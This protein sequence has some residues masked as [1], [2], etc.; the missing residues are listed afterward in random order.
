[1][2]SKAVLSP[3][4][5]LLCL[6]FASG[7]FGGLRG[8]EQASTLT[9]DEIVLEAHAEPIYPDAENVDIEYSVINHSKNAVIVAISDGLMR[10]KLIAPDGKPVRPY[11]YRRDLSS[12]MMYTT[13]SI[14]PGGRF[15]NGMRI[16]ALYPFPM[17]GVYRCTLTKRVYEWVS[18]D[19][20][21]ELYLYETNYYGK[22]VDVTA[23]E[24]RFQ[25]LKPTRPE[26][27][28]PKVDPMNHIEEAG[29][30]Y[31]KMPSKEYPAR[32][33]EARIEKPHPNDVRMLPQDNDL[34]PSAPQ[35][36]STSQNKHAT[37]MIGSHESSWLVW[38]LVVLAATVCA[39]WVFLRKTK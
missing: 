12:S 13:K 20:P 27:S 33:G 2:K 8:A 26:R 30:E 23:P 22:P 1:M 39:G 21:D 34:P 25:V 7:F 15:D 4:F 3:G 35:P 36:A 11:P 6:G 5:V 18:P 17:G 32:F 14:P 28:N 29:L 16:S 38:L 19:V 31:D 24:L 37:L 9:K 10:L